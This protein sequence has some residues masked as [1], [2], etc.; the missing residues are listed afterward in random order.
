[1]S[2]FKGE[3]K[4]DRAAVIAHVQEA[5]PNMTIKKWGAMFSV[6]A[7]PLVGTWVGVNGKRINTMPMVHGILWAPVF[8]LLLASLIGIVLY[9]VLFIPKQKKQMLEV[10]E[11]LKRFPGVQS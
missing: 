9:A 11:V 1:M 7:H 4:F 3:E 10:D 6:G 2:T 8:L 5:F